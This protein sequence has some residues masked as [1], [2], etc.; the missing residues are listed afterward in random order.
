MPRIITSGYIKIRWYQQSVHG[1]NP[2]CSLK[3]KLPII[4]IIADNQAKRIG[5]FTFGCRLF[6]HFFE[7]IHCLS[8][9]L[10]SIN[11]NRWRLATPKLFAVDMSFSHAAF[12][13]FSVKAFITLSV[14]SGLAT[15]ANV[16]SKNCQY[17]DLLSP[18]INC[19]AAC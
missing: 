9:E 14:S 6:H 18:K 3:N 8:F 12:P 5:L 13:L 17:I 10:L 4:A 15:S 11:K 16:S 2:I 19:Q 7:I 1:I